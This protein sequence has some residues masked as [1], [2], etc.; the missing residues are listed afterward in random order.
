MLLVSSMQNMAQ[1]GQVGGYRNPLIFGQI[2]IFCSLGATVFTDHG[3]IW[4][5]KVHHGSI[6]MPNLALIWEGGGYSSPHRVFLAVFHAAWA[7]LYT[8]QTDVL[9]IGT[10]QYPN[11]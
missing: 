4:H 1:I 11:I 6:L 3:E 5:G 8:N 2:C 9:N 7:T 10:I